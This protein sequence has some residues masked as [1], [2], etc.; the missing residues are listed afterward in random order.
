MRI[1]IVLCS[2]AL[3][4]SSC[5]KEPETVVES[6]TGNTAETPK[7]APPIVAKASIASVILS[8]DCP[9]EVVKSVTAAREIAPAGK[10]SSAGDMAGDMDIR[11]VECQQSM[12][13]IAFDGQGDSAAKV[14]VKAV[15][16]LSEN[17]EFL[18]LLKS[19]SP[20][21]WTKD[22][23]GQWNGEIP[24]SS[25]IKTRYKLSV[26]NWTE[27]ENKS[28]SPNSMR[29]LEVELDIGGVLQKVSTKFRRVMAPPAMMIQT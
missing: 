8:D 3:L 24:A 20:S 29:V 14:E 15:R 4:V 27:L 17:G 25:S 9:D 1:P 2:L 11:D 12:M 6:P 10:R 13:Q 28:D 19:R 18:A 5:S 26:P 16:I 22:R 23:Y 7:E 21:I